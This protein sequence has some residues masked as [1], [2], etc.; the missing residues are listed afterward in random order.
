M[1]EADLGSV[2]ALSRTLVHLNVPGMRPIMERLLDDGNA[3]LSLAAYDWLARTSDEQA[4]TILLAR[5]ESE[6]SSDNERWL[7]AEA[8]GRRGESD[9]MEPVRRVAGRYLTVVQDPRR[10]HDHLVMANLNDSTARLLVRLAVTEAQLGGENLAAIPVVLAYPEAN[11]NREPIVRAEA[12]TALGA[13]AT[14][15]TLDALLNAL[16][17]EDFEVAERAIR[18]LQLIGAREAVDTLIEGTAP[19]RLELAEL[20]LTAIVA[21][22]GPG[23]GMGH[24]VFDLAPDE[25]RSWWE[26]E[27]GRFSSGVCY[28]LGR[29]FSLETLIDL[30]QDPDQR[31]YLADEIRIVTGFD[32]DYDEALPPN[33]Q[34]SIVYAAQRGLASAAPNYKV[35]RL[36]KFGYERNLSKVLRGLP[37]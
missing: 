35:G 36:Y 32:L 29:P 11:R 4:G 31:P 16:L 24:S 9:A 27:Q 34:E 23:P 6:K 26:T 7:A 20:A 12:V 19:E 25:L 21:V 30:L 2:R 18:P 1:R 17:A 33:G 10:L 22:T 3:D 37:G 14:V 15:G 13:V 5:L 28:R 8:L